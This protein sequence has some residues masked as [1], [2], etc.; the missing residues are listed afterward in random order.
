MCALPPYSIQILHELYSTEAAK[1]SIT[2][3]LLEL[4]QCLNLHRVDINLKIKCFINKSQ[5][6]NKPMRSNFII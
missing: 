4:S 6:K 3:T 1:L 5:N 2:N